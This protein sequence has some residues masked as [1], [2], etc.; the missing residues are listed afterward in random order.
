[1]EYQRKIQQA[2]DLL[3]AAREEAEVIRG[4]SI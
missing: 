1:M 3:N 2:E 4:G